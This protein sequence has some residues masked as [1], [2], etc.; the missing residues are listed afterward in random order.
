MRRFTYRARLLSPQASDRRKNQWYKRAGVGHVCPRL[1][2]AAT[3]STQLVSAPAAGTRAQR[4][5]ENL[6]SL[7]EHGEL[8]RHRRNSFAESSS[9]LVT[10]IGAFGIGVA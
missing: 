1:A 4:L 5:S 3:E 8:G 2:S 10:A 7:A 6:A 9:Y